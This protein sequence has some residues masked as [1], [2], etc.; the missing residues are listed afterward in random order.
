MANKVTFDRNRIYCRGKNEKG[1]WVFG[2]LLHCYDAYGNLET[3]IYQ[4]EKNGGWAKHL[5]PDSKTIARF[6]GYTVNGQEIWEKN[7]LYFGKDYIGLICF[8]TY[9]E[10]S[11]SSNTEH[12]GFYVEWIT[13][14]NG[15]IE[16]YPLLRKD[17]GYWLR[18]EEIKIAKE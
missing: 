13:L 16:P 2:D 9:R 4:S 18:K 5:I 3:F 8:G 1:E 12:L 15:W 6:T 7:K 17:L 14:V 11:D 10:S